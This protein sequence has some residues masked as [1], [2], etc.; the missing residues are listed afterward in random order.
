M[1]RVIRGHSNGGIEMRFRLGFSLLIEIF[2][3]FNNFQAAAKDY[4]PKILEEAEWCVDAVKLDGYQ[5][6]NREYLIQLF[7]NSSPFNGIMDGKQFTALVNWNHVK[8]KV[9][10]ELE[11]ESVILAGYFPRPSYDR[12]DLAIILV[13]TKE[14]KKQIEND[15]AMAKKRF[16]ENC[17]GCELLGI[18]EPSPPK[19][20]KP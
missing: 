9:E 12:P 2:L 1:V 4:C 7:V 14:R 17:F 8:V 10:K 13:K 3:F 20:R 11:R 15:I 6:P 16:A 5:F 18:K 19:P